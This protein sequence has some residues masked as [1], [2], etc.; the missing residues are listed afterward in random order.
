MIFNTEPIDD[1]E[2]DVESVPFKFVTTVCAVLLTLIIIVSSCP[3]V[4][5]TLPEVTDE[6]AP[7]KYDARVAPVPA[8]FLI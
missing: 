3:A 1:I 4:E 2:D 5:V 8:G 6:D 7:P